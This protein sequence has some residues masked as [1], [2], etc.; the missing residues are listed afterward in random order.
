MDIEIFDFIKSLNLL[1][2]EYKMPV[3][4]ISKITGIDENVIEDIANEKVNLNVLSIDKQ[5]EFLDFL[6]CLV[7]GIPG[8]DEYTRIHSIIDG[9]TYQ[10]GIPL[11]TIAKFTELDVRD[12][13]LFLENDE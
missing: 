5:D 6:A 7:E 4:S 12:L 8:T 10:Y 9:L 11:E 13:E 2:Q 3:K 1:I